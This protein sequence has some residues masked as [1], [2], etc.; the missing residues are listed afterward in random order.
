[1]RLAESLMST[2]GGLE[3]LRDELVDRLCAVMLTV[4]AWDVA[5]ACLALWLALHEPDIGRFFAV[6]AAVDC[7]LV[8]PLLCFPGN[9]GTGV[10]LAEQALAA[11]VHLDQQGATT[12][13]GRAPLNSACVPSARV[14]T[15]SRSA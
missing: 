4:G 13:A 2:R 5:P 1:V 15:N 14:A 3:G 12:K 11:L 10:L 6:G 8:P 9:K 7:G